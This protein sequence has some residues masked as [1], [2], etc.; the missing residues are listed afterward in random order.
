MI[1][2]VSGVEKLFGKG[3]MFFLLSGV[4]KLVCL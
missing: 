4:S 3:D 1:L 2:D